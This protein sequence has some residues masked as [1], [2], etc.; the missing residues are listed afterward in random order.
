EL[1][2]AKAMRDAGKLSDARTVL[3]RVAAD[4][5]EVGYGPVEALAFLQL[6][7][8]QLASGDAREADGNLA[9]SARVADTAR[10]DV[11]RARALTRQ[12]Y[13]EGVILAQFDRVAMLDED[14][15][16][17]IARLGGDEE[18]EADRLQ[19]MGMALLT[20]GDLAGAAGSLLRAIALRRKVFGP[21]G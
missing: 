16:A 15:S 20:Q 10:D 7:D 11:T 2:S 17:V 9:H 19:A 5:R 8:V 21:R 4:S 14:C 1:A 3:E 12:L 6:G 18:L 13:A